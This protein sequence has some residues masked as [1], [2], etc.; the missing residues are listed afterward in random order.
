MK[1][2]LVVDDD[3]VIQKLLGDILGRE[4]YQVVSVMDGIDAIVAVRKDKPDLV[5]LDIIMPYVNGYDVCRTIKLDP[6]LKEIPIVVLTSRDQ[7]VD[8]RI[9]SLIGVEYLHKT[10]KPQELLAKIQNILG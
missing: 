6:V 10:C 5:V 9:L 2:I 7:E 8:K 4:G 3:P 1:K